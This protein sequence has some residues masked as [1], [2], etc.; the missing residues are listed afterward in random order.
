MH[1]CAP[2]LVVAGR[3]A[4]VPILLVR[5]G[6]REVAIQVD[7]LRGT[8]EVVIKALGPQLAEL[9]GLAGATIMATVGWC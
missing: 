8:R 7:G 2:G 4:Q 5:T 9:K 6:T 1:R 3:G